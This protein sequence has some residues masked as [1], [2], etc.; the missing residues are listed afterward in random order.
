MTNEL[1]PCPFC[2]GKA[3]LCEHKFRSDTTKSS[4][5]YGIKC[6]RCIAQSFQFYL[7]EAE[8]ID[9]WNRRYNDGT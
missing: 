2:G 7:S 1:K 5:L 8:A 9:G 6:K 4:S 3:E